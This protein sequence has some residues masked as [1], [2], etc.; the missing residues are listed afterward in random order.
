MRHNIGQMFSTLKDLAPRNPA[1]GLR[2]F[3]GRGLP[4]GTP[5]WLHMAF[6]HRLANYNRLVTYQLSNPRKETQ[7]G[8]P[9]KVVGEVY[10]RLERIKQ[11]TKEI[12][13]IPNFGPDVWTMREGDKKCQQILQD[14]D[15][16]H[17]QV[18][19]YIGS[20]TG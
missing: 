6:S 17:Q 2:A 4:Y 13:A 14:T 16:V 20:G 8:M 1:S 7:M 9:S 5:S 12:E 15:W 18:K 11:L 10:Q 19:R 3:T